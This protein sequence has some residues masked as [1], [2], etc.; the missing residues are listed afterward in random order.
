MLFHCPRILAFIFFPFN[1]PNVLKAKDTKLSKSETEVNQ[2]FIYSLSENAGTEFWVTN[3]WLP[4]FSSS[5]DPFSPT[6]TL[7]EGFKTTNTLHISVSIL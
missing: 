2:H 4:N 7:P 5:G 1:L 3:I 6:S